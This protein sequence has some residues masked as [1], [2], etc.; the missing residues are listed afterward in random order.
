M[1][2]PFLSF[3]LSLSLIIRAIRESARNIKSL[4]ESEREKE[5]KRKNLRSSCPI[6]TSLPI[7]TGEKAAADA[8]AAALKEEENRHCCCCRCTLS[9]RKNNF[10]SSSGTNTAV[11]AASSKRCKKSW[12]RECRQGA[13]DIK[14]LPFFILI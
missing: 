9:K 3:S 6:S 4:G 5:R 11:T 12:N 10:G 13:S 1:A 14:P 8:A 7:S 2:F